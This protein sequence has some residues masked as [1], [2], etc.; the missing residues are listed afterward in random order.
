MADHVRRVTDTAEHA[1]T[2]AS[3]RQLQLLE[4]GV[5]DEFVE[6]CAQT[7]LRY[8]LAYGTLLGAV[9]HRG[10]IPWDD[11]IDVA[12][13][14]HDYDRLAE[15]VP[16]H[17][18]GRFALHSYRTDALYPYVFAKL[19]LRGTHLRQMNDR[20]R[21]FARGVGIDIFP[22][23]GVPR[24]AAAKKVRAVVVRAFQ[25]RLSLG[26]RPSSRLRQ[27]RRYLV[28]PLPFGL[29][30]SLYEWTV[31]R[32]PA[33]AADAWVCAGPYADRVTFPREWFGDGV[34]LDF[35]GL[36]LTAPE[37]W[38]RYLTKVYGDYM[39]L[40]PPEARVSKHNLVRVDLGQGG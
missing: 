15:L 27:W 40:P 10:F 17:F 19:S 36:Q 30:R 26:R 3:L 22:L 8:Y 16:K 4:L 13:P 1:S 28:R 12:M 34:Q 35:E 21:S 37:E 31:V 7:G 24:S 20:N 39:T 5:L 2:D 32:W 14:R 9:R 18:E 6:F 25:V 23:D 38:D 11:D 29:L 33:S